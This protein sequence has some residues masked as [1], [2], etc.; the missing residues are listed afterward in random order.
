MTYLGFNLKIN[1][2]GLGFEIKK[3]DK[4]YNPNKPNCKNDGSVNKFRFSKSTYEFS[5]WYFAFSF[6]YNYSFI[7]KIYLNRG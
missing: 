5:D 4:N 6:F 7:F 3:S 2:Y 1:G